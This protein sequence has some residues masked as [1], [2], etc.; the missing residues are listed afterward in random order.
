[1]TNYDLCGCGARKP[2]SKKECPD[3]SKKIDV[4]AG[5][6]CQECGGKKKPEYNECYQC[7]NDAQ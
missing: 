4:D 1:M 3:C 2:E 7:Y 6:E 5:E